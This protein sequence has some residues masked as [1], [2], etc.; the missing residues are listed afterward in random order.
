MQPELI[1][2]IAHE[3]PFLKDV[4]QAGFQ[5]PAG[6]T[7][8]LQKTILSNGG[9]SGL[10]TKMSFVYGFPSD[11]QALYVACWIHRPVEK[12]SYMIPLTESQGRG[13]GQAWERLSSRWSSHMSKNAKSA[14]EGYSFLKGY[15][16]LLVQIEVDR[17]GSTP[18]LFLKTEGHGAMSVAHLSSF[19][20]KLRHGEGNT[21]SEA[22]NRLAK[23]GKLGIEPR[24]AENY[25]NAYKEVLKNLRLSGKMVTAEEAIWGMCEKLETKAA[26]GK[27]SFVNR[28]LWDSWKLRRRGMPNQRLANLDLVELIEKVIL[29]TINQSGAVGGKNVWAMVAASQDLKRMA[30]NLRRDA[31]TAPQVTRVFEE[32]RVTQG[33]LDQSLRSFVTDLWQEVR[34]S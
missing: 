13:V 27:A 26:Q 9:V 8:Y 30:N 3:A 19:W 18:H 15:S 24:A 31:L 23:E 14:G 1:H 5:S 2:A 7:S 20:N 16:E 22:L 6:W 34:S 21:Q 11:F 10:L 12:G 25:S 4:F 29:P 28:P 33:E 17:G 32:V